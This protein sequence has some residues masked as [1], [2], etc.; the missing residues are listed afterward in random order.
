MNYLLTPVAFCQKQILLDILDIFSL[1]M[2]QSKCSLLKKAFEH[3]SVPFFPLASCFRA[4]LLG[5][6]QK[7]KLRY[8]FF[9]E[10]VTYIFRIF[11][12]FCFF[13]PFSP[14][15]IFLLQ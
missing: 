12:G 14:F 10:K 3:D 9:D 1:D 6:V 7:S 13:F 5:H 11:V 4:F 15:L 8:H 2:S